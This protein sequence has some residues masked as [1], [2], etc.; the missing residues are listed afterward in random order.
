MAMVGSVKSQNPIGRMPEHK[1][2]ATERMYRILSVS[3]VNVSP[4]RPYTEIWDVTDNP[5]G[6]LE[7]RRLVRD[8]T[9]DPIA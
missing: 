4:D 3:F 8:S 6:L 2:N 7:T 1:P 9:L 5:F